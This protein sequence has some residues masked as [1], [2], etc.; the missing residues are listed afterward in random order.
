MRAIA[1]TAVTI[2]VPAPSNAVFFTRSGAA[3]VANVVLLGEYLFQLV[4]DETGRDAPNIA[5]LT[6]PR[7]PRAI[8]PSPSS[9][10]SRSLP[11]QRRP[12]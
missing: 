5:W 10:P 2:A 12:S 1:G 6:D 3:L 7:R 9:S 4:V 11:Q 8:P